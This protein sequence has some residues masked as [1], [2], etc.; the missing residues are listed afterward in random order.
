MNFLPGL[1]LIYVSSIKIIFK[2]WD[3]M[4]MVSFAM[5]EKIFSLLKAYFIN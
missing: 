4:S 5:A 2:T 1:T 3:T